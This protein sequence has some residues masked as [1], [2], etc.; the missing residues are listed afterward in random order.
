MTPLK[1]VFKNQFGEEVIGT[2]MNGPGQ[3]SSLIFGGEGAPTAAAPENSLYIRTDA[4]STDA[5]IYRNT[6]GGT[7]W[8]AVDP[9][10]PTD[11]I[12]TVLTGYVSGAGTVAD[13]DSILEAIEK[14]N[15][16]QVLSKATADAALPS[17]SF[18]SAAVTAK[19]LTGLASGTATPIAATDTILAALANL[20]AQIDAL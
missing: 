3:L 7:T 17:A 6:D 4:S 8:A 5:W 13:T 18:T 14:L 1:L 20:Q 2:M 12:S 11:I 10:S 16:N 9:Q 15:G 19:V